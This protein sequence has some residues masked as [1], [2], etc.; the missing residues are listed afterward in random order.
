MS[1][2]LYNFVFSL[3]EENN[4]FKLFIFPDS[5]SGGVSN[6]KVRDEIERD[7]KISN[8]TATDLQDDITGP[9]IIEE[10]R[11]QVSKGMKNDEYMRILAIY[12]SSIFQEIENCLRT[13]VYL[14]EDDI[15]LVLDE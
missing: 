12:N 7:L 11:E 10:Y 8:I 1:L 14:V 5:K 9:K 3:T 13:E 2:E 15:R 4:K 6:K